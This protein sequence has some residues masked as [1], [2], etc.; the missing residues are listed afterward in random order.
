VATPTGPRADAARAF[1]RVRRRKLKQD[2]KAFFTAGLEPSP[3]RIMTL[4]VNVGGAGYNV[5]DEFL[6]SGGTFSIQGRG[7][8]VAEAGNVVTQVAVQIAGAYTVTP[9]VG[10]ATVA[11]TGGGNNALTVDVTL[12][13]LHDFGSQAAGVGSPN[14]LLLPA[15]ARFAVSHSVGLSPEDM[16]LSTFGPP[17]VGHDNAET[18]VA[19]GIQEIR[20]YYTKNRFLHVFRRAG[21]PAGLL[22]VYFLGPH[23]TRTLIATATWT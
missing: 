15:N 20:H 11:Q 23:N 17:E 13:G 1:Y 12:S 3:F 18:T 8:V 7:Y 10:A 9:G 14:N 5:G 21:S 16:S 19:D 6:I 22:S 4:A 2:E